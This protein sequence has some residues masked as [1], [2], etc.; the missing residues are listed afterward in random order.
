[1]REKLLFELVLFEP[2]S[3]RRRFAASEA[4]K[5]FAHALKPV[6]I[7]VTVIAETFRSVLRKGVQLPYL[8]KWS[9]L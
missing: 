8:P 7:T 9:C 5:V 4:K 2:L 6:L 1:M 3:K